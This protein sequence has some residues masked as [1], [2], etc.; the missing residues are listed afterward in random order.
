MVHI[1]SP[2]LEIILKCTVYGGVANAVDIVWRGPA[3]HSQPAVVET[4]DGN[5]TSNVILT[6]V[7]M[8]FSG[9]YE[10]TARYINTLCTSSISSDLRLDVVAPPLVVAQTQSPH[11]VNGGVNVGLQFQF[12]THPPFTNVTCSSPNGEISFTRVNN[13]DAFQIALSITI[14]HINHTQGGNYACTA[15]NS[16]G[17]I[18]A[19]T[20]LIVRPDVV[21]Q[22]ILARN[23]DS[24]SLTCLV[25]SFP[26]PDFIWEKYVDSNSVPD[27]FSSSN[28]SSK[29]AVTAS[30][31]TFESIQYGNA[32]VYHCVV[33]FNTTLKVSSN[34]SILAGDLN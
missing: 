11:I 17:A 6:D 27:Q 15:N 28:E 5:Y 26:E 10:C 24:V 2:D 12:L 25:Q 4:N 3:V 7:T 16:A 18:T 1:E 33:T 23:G 34:E 9:V 14:L 8:F 22:Q 20:L 21:P 19:T 13:E 30:Y 29:N 31:L 32:G